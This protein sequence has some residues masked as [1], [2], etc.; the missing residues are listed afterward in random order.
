MTQIGV[1]P[2]G[3]P[4]ATLTQRE[5]GPRRVFVLGVYA[6]AVHARWIGADGRTRISA[7]GVA[8]E[9]EIF[10]TG[11]GADEMI[12]HV[13]IRE[14]AG[15][16]ESAGL[17]LNGPT[18]RALDELYLEP[19][20]ITRRDAWL[21]DLVPHSCMN[22]EQSRAI[23]RAY[24][25]LMSAV[26]LP[27]VNWPRVPT[28]ANDWQK[29]VDRRRKEQILSEVKEA[30]PEILVTLGDLPLRWF[31]Q[32]FGTRPRLAEYG[33]S[34]DDYGRLHKATIGGHRLQLLPL[35]HPR[36][37]AR[38]GPSSPQWATLH[39]DWVA[40][41]APGLFVDTPQHNTIQPTSIG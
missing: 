34:G 28:S 13:A 30:S 4:I 2:F 27:E 18:G 8:S 35:T 39:R 40:N 41:R 10:W 14:D 1:F 21:C 19:L 38:L 37:A 9:P 26:S 23:E 3:Q 20:G 33:G 17:T 11:L 7:L 29:L 5:R 24:R 15:Y 6:S 12:R 31:T 22:G 25:P 16:L 32:F 36:Q